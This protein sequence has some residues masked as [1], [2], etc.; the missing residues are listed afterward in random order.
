MGNFRIAIG[1]AS[2]REINT[3]DK[4][5]RAVCDRVLQKLEH[6]KRLNASQ[7]NILKVEEQEMEVLDGKEVHLTTYCESTSDNQTIVVVQAF[8]PTWWL[9]NYISLSGVGKMLAEGVVATSDGKV[10]DATGDELWRFR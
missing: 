8:Y 4:T 3:K 5:L 9:P 1:M 6:L 2:C 7:L 10:R